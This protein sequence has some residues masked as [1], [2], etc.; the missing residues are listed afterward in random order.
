M[1]LRHDLPLLRL[2]PPLTTAANQYA[3]LITRLL[4]G[5]GS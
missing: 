1:G 4:L 5:V 2:A 3:A